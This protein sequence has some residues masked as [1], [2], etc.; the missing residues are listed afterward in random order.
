MLNEVTATVP[1]EEAETLC[2]AALAILLIFFTS[3]SYSSFCL[4]ALLI[5]TGARVGEGAVT[6]GTTGGAMV[7]AATEAEA[8]PPAQT[9]G[10]EVA[11][12]KATNLAWLPKSQH[13]CES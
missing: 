10:P 2:Q 7:T 11:L 4:E 5:V 6:L 3:F 9:L 8:V 12:W 1:L 13:A